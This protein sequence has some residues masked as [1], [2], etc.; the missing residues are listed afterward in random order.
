[1]F[2]WHMQQVSPAIAWCQPHQPVEATEAVRFASKLKSTIGFDTAAETLPEK[3]EAEADDANATAPRKA[4]WLEALSA[5]RQ[6]AAAAKTSAQART[7]RIARAI[8]ATKV[9]RRMWAAGGERC[10]D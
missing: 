5:R 3:F 1:M 10:L 9:G 8:E 4:V 6:G 7:K 2:T